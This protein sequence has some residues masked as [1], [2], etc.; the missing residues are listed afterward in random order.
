MLV[1]LNRWQLA[2]I[3]GF[4]DLQDLACNAR[5]KCCD[6]TNCTLVFVLPILGMSDI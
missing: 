1:I 6:R 5:F 3:G 2:Y 4:F